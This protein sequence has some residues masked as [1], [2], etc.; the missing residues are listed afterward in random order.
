MSSSIALRRSP[1]PG[2]FT[3]A[4][5]ERAADLVHDERRERLALDVLGHDQAAACPGCATC[6]SSGSR[7]FMLLIFFSWSRISGILEHDLHRARGRSRSRA[8]GSRGRT[9]CPR[10]P[11]ASVSIALGLLDGDHAFLADL[12]HRLGEHLAD[13]LVAVGR[14]RAD[15]GDLLASRVGLDCLASSSTIAA[16][17]LS[18]PRL[19]SIGFMPGGDELRCPRGRSPARARSRWWCRRR[20]RRRSCSATSRTIC[21]PMF[22]N[23]SSS[24]I[25]LATVTPSLVT[26]GEP[27]LFSIITLRPLGPSVTRTALASWSTPR[28]QPLAGVLSVIGSPWLTWISSLLEHR[29]D[30]VLADD[31]VFVAVDLDLGAGVLAE[32]HPVALLHVERAA[33]CRRRRPCR[34]RRR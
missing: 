17:A 33:S 12:L 22:S 9:A 24:S 25:S 32:Q 31:Q 27:Q 6:S 10:P 20:R 19:R 30:V 2:A 7:S 18:M 8:R 4:H 26:V 16:T 15:L 28:E 29:E 34:C 5:C 3:A 1:K 13:R 23:L 11:R 14:D 21:A